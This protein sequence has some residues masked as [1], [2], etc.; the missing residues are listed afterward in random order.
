MPNPKERAAPAWAQERLCC[1]S[2]EPPLFRAGTVG[3]H[4]VAFE[5]G[6]TSCPPPLSQAL[7]CPEH[8][9]IPGQLGYSDQRCGR[10]NDTR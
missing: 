2:H 4:T 6:R 8:I 9:S 5:E 7:H 3:W 1:L 10:R